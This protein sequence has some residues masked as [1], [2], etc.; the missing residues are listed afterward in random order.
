MTTLL[1]L[2]ALAGILVLLSGC[3]M[4]DKVND[5]QQDL[6]EI[7]TELQR[8]QR[9]QSDTL[10]R[11]EQ[12]EDQS[13]NNSEQVTKADLADV[14][15]GIGQIARDVAIV[16]ER[17]NDMG[18]RIDRLSQQVQQAREMNRSGMY[19]APIPA[20]GPE[21]DS[22]NGSNDVATG[23]VAG[24][25]AGSAGAVP[26][27]E[28]LYNTAYADF[29]KGNYAL[30]ISGFEEYHEK[31]AG[32]ALADN[33]IYWVGECHFSQGNFGDAVQA[34]DRLLELYPTSDKAPASNL[35]KG[36]AYLEQNQVGKA[37]VQLRFVVSEYPGSDEAKIA[38]DK[39]TSLGAQP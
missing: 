35:K 29:S 30:A 14:T 1:R 18:R 9:G 13:S 5:M 3:V 37:I 39:L 16:D 27:P 4:P 32:T 7:Q 21:T 22:G 34:F 33:A 17:I 28:Q 10:A 36:L 19:G 11:L 31:F 8:V 15:V 20:G 26:D 23:A 25:A 6:A 2:I 24:G 38:R 12:L